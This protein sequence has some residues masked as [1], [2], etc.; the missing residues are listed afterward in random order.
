M[1]R[2]LIILVYLVIIG[3]MITSC[4]K[5]EYIN[6]PVLEDSVEKVELAKDVN[7]SALYWKQLDREKIERTK[8]YIKDEFGINLSLDIIKDYDITGEKTAKLIETSDKGGMFFFYFTN[9]DTINKLIDSGKILPLNKFLESNTTWQ[10]LPMEM[11]NMYSVDDDNIWT[12]SRGYSQHVFGR[13]FKS[14]NIEQLGIEIPDTLAQF[15]DMLKKDNAKMPYYNPLS[16]NDIFYANNT[17]LALS[18]NGWNVTSIVYDTKT[19]SYEDSMLKPDMEDTLNYVNNLFSNK[20]VQMA[21]SRR[22]IGYNTVSVLDSDSI[23]TNCYG[24]I[25]NSFFNN[26]KYEIIYGLTGTNNENI[27]PLSYN[28][29][30]N[31]YYVLAANT[32]NAKE[33]INTFVSIF[34][35][36]VK[37]YISTKYGPPGEHYI[38]NGNTVIIK[39]VDFF[40]INDFSIVTTNPLIDLGTIDISTSNDINEVLKKYNK[41]KLNKQQ[42]ITN[43]LSS[44]KM[45][46]L[47]RSQAYPEVFPSLDNYAFSNPASRLFENVF[48]NVF[49]GFVTTNEGVI[50]YKETMKQLGEQKIIDELNSKIGANTLY[51]Y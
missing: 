25:P 36:D 20:L 33:V 7:L 45:F 16:I 23:Y 34:Y 14:D 6:R 13:V 30:N 26:D 42:Y 37:G 24:I 27:N 41:E 1:K 15:Y 17:P 50:E 28:Y 2:F 3:M 40:H 39:D 49:R 32:E 29:I 9:L 5:T 19:N 21:G 12:L 8:Q 18:H 44:N 51:K 47:T 43:G 4:E 35:G 31:G 46:N 48:E 22:Q 11:K 10:A 38:F